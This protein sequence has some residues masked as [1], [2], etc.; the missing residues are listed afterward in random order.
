M[1][2]D[3]RVRAKQLARLLAGLDQTFREDF[4][5]SN[6]IPYSLTLA[7]YQVISMVAEKG[8]QSQ[9]E[10]ADELRVTGPTVVRIIDALEKKH[11]VSRMRHSRDRRVVLVFLTDE[12]R[13]VQRECAA[14]HEQRLAGMIERLPYNTADT[15]LQALR[16]LLVA[17]HS[18]ATSEEMAGVP[19]TAAG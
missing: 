12:G 6:R 10:I 7:Q 4:K 8:R 14:V 9:K 3:S 11:L 13:K 17:A 18:G 15:L 2:G 16:D 5:R 19:A 1:G